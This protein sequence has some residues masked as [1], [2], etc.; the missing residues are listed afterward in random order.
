MLWDADQ[1]TRSITIDFT[2]PD[3]ILSLYSA[4]AD[5]RDASE[6]DPDQI[7]GSAASIVKT[8]AYYEERADL[9]PL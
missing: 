8:L 6:E 3:H 9:T 1:V 2:N 7:Y 5:L 4:R